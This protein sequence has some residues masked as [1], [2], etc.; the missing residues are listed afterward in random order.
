MADHVD[1]RNVELRNKHEMNLCSSIFVLLV[2]GSDRE[3]E[4]LTIDYRLIF[5]FISAMNPIIMV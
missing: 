3:Q 4:S 2:P 5:T 1:T